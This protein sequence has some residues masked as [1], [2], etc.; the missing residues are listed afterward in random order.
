M[1]FGP[2]VKVNRSLAS[3]IRK[4]MIARIVEVQRTVPQSVIGFTFLILLKIV[5]RDHFAQPNNTGGVENELLF[6]LG[7]VENSDVHEISDA[8]W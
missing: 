6:L 8:N 2:S 3:T 4:K 5:V 7:K 1:G